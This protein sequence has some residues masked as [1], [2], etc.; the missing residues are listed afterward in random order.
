MCTNAAFVPLVYFCY[1]E[2]ANLT[3]EEIDYIFMDS[4]SL[5]DEVKLSKEMRRQKMEEGGRRRSLTR[6]STGGE[7]RRDTLVE[8][9]GGQE[10]SKDAV[11]Q[12]GG[13]TEHLEHL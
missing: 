12:V 7:S 11:G 3:L 4:N 2:T 13:K 5:K 9:D 10:K 6:G 8:R 1:P